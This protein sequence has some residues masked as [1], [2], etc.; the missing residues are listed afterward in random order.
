MAISNGERTREEMRAQRQRTK[1]RG[2]AATSCGEIYI[3]ECNSL[4]KMENLC[5]FLLYL[6]AA[7][8]LYILKIIDYIYIR[9][10]SY[11]AYIAAPS[12]DGAVTSALS[13]IFVYDFHSD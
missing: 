4:M 1:R 9:A 12:S 13:R 10:R 5:V 3:I 8:E 2:S 6:A 11:I 7:H